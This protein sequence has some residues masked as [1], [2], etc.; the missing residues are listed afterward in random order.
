MKRLLIFALLLLAGCG[1]RLPPMPEDA[2]A[3]R[4]EAVPGKAVIYLARH[5]AEPTFIAPVTLDEQMIGSTYSGTYMRIETTA[6]K[7][8]LSGMA[9]DNG[10][11][12]L[13]T[14]PGKLYFVQHS[15][16]GY[17]T[18]VSSSFRL[19]DASYGRSLVMGGEISALIS[20]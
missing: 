4:F 15:A 13:D 2:V 16:R 9:G 8:R 11:I 5:R 17:R 19:V 7:H 14:E 1:A 12:T 10:G 3:K 6:G 20:Q 18:F